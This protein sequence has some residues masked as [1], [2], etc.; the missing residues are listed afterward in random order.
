MGNLQTVSNAQF[1]TAC[2]AVPPPFGPLTRVG[3]VPSVAPNS[4]IATTVTSA[5][6]FSRTFTISYNDLTDARTRDRILREAHAPDYADHLVIGSLLRAATAVHLSTG[7]APMSKANYSRL[8]NTLLY[9]SRVFGAHPIEA[10]KEVDTNQTVRLGTITPAVSGNNVTLTVNY[11]GAA[12][13]L[14]VAYNRHANTNDAGVVF[15]LTSS[16]QTLPAFNY[17]AAGTYKPVVV[18]VGPGGV[19]FRVLSVTV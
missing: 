3:N 5:A 13:Y 8:I 1:D 7:M 16:P 9:T 14:V 6:P 2:A 12:E 11:S 15:N 19:D 17:G 4:H 10:W 18:L